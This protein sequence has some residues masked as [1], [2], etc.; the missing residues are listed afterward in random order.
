MSTVERL[1]TKPVRDTEEW[2][3][4]VDLAAAFRLAVEF[5]WHEGVANHF[6][7]AVSPDGRKFLLNPRWKHFSMIRASDLNLYPS[8]NAI[9]TVVAA[10]D[11]RNVDTVV[12][13]GVV[14][15]Y[16]GALVGFDAAAHKRL[17]EESRAY[18]F[19][20]KGHKQDPFAA[21]FEM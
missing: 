17:V 4:R 18:L 19:Q 7:L 11:S 16:K 9:G 3:L 21:A 14:R 1:K 20:A 10:A 2:Q 12:I 5:D 15:K 13:G 6:S 8:N